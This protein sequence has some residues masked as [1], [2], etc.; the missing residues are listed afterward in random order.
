MAASASRPFRTGPGVHDVETTYSPAPTLQRLS[1]AGITPLHQRQV[2]LNCRP[3]LVNCH[4]LVSCSSSCLFFFLLS[5]NRPRSV[6]VRDRRPGVRASSP[7]AARMAA[8]PGSGRASGPR[9]GPP[10]RS[11]GAQATICI[12]RQ[13]GEG[14][15]APSPL[16]GEPVLS[17]VEGGWGEGEQAN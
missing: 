7:Q 13:R 2:T 8:L 6:L 12:T 5:P 14:K 17:P 3:S 10:D 15:S 4:P 1:S 9:R 11:R 16:E